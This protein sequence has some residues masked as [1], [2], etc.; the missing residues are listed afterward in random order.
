MSRKPYI[1]IRAAEEKSHVVA[2][3]LIEVLK[4]FNERHPDPDAERVAESLGDINHDYIIQMCALTLAE[5]HIVGPDIREESNRSGL[6]F[7][8]RERLTSKRSEGDMETQ[9]N[10]GKMETG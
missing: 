4:Q 5:T 2:N 8:L 1:T 10:K 7:W 6:R 9:R 3:E